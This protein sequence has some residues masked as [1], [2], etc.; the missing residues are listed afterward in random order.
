MS[1]KSI[2]NKL[3]ESLGTAFVHDSKTE[4]GKNGSFSLTAD[5]GE[6]VPIPLRK[7]AIVIRDEY[8]EN[9]Y[10][11]Q[12]FDYPARLFGLFSAPIESNMYLETGKYLTDLGR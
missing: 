2:T 9:N 10:F 5:L 7:G 6:D 8:D 3:A 1:S 4:D 12:Y 11:Y